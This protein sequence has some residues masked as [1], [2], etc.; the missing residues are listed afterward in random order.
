MEL[1]E[2]TTNDSLL[3]NLNSY[4]KKKFQVC[5]FEDLFSVILVI[6]VCE[7]LQYLHL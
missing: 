5:K 1:P 7:S 4:L 6:Y 2:G 3:F